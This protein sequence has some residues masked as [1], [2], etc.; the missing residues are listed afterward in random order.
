MGAGL[1]TS[2]CVLFTATS[3]YARRLVPLVVRD[4]CAD[5]AER[6]DATLRLYD[7]LCF[8]SIT[9][10]Q[11]RNDLASVVH[12]AARFADT[13]ARQRDVQDP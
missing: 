5:A 6:H 11:V 8:Q 2:V 12:L 13:Q 9:A 3:A 10:A 7:G 1:E 4:A